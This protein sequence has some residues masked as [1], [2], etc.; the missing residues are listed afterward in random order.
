MM[1]NND[2]KS[3]IKQLRQADFGSHYIVIYPNLAI[4]R[5]IYS[6]YALTQIEENNEIVVLIPYYET[7]DSVRSVLQ[8]SMNSSSNSTNTSNAKKIRKYEKQNRLV[9]IDSVKAY[10][11]LKMGLES[12]IQNLVEHAKSTGR[13][14]V[15]VITDAGS[16]S[17]FEIRESL[18][19]YELNL[20]SHYND[21]PL[22]RFCIYNQAELNTF[23]EEKKQKLLKHHTI[24]LIV[25]T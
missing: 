18:V 21:L 2:A 7:T 12:F 1:T 19:E 8:K 6:N 3:V 17:L 24:N 23:P 5:E 25:T 14:G 4:L 16:F 10:F 22:K 11:T 20:P 13:N 9:I 15:S